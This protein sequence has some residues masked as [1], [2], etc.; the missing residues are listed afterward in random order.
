M[1]ACK[2]LLPH[3]SEIPERGRRDLFMLAAPVFQTLLGRE[4]Q[5]VRD[6]FLTLFTTA[7]DAVASQQKPSLANASPS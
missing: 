5:T 2:R 7:T 3:R 1:E 4:G 6:E